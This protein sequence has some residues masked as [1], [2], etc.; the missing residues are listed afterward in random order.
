MTPEPLINSGLFVKAKSISVL[1]V[2][3]TRVGSLIIAQIDIHNFGK[4]V[5]V[6]IGFI[7]SQKRPIAVEIT[8]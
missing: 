8:N 3:V 6:S 2:A 4:Y 7:I 5:C 1:V